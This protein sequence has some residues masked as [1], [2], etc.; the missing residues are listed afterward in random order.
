[1]VGVRG[2]HVS[3]GYRN[4]AHDAGVFDGSVFNTGDL[5]CL[6]DDGRL[7]IAGRAEDLIIRR[8]ANIDSLMIENAMALHPAVTTAAAA[9]WPD[10]HAGERPVCFV[11]LRPGAQVGVD[12]LLSTH[13]RTS[14]SASVA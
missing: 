4:P 11:A 5:A 1:M 12:E 7:H 14:A 9:G 6:D 3:P 8:G 10:A 2:P 13:K